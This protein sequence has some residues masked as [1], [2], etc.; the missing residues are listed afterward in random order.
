[1]TVD[2][3]EYGHIRQHLEDMEKEIYVD[4]LTVSYSGYFSYREFMDMVNR[5]CEEKGYYREVQSSSEKVTEKGVNKGFSLQLQRKISP[6]HLSVLNIDIS[7]E[8]M[9]DETKEVDGRM[10]NLNKGDVEAVFYG[11]LMS[12]RKSRWETKAYTYFFRTLIDKF[13]YKFDKPKYRGTVIQDGKDFAR[14]MRGFL[15]LY[16]KKIKD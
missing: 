7:F 11:Y 12:S 4:K 14:K 2:E 6:V 1:M 8:N 13:I 15:E 5:W 9:T 10:K 3:L 16:E